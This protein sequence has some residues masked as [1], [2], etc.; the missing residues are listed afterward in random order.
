MAKRF[1]RAFTIVELV[2]VIAVI[3]ILA[4]VLIPTFT[5]LID[6]ANESADLQAVQQMNTIL[7]ANSADEDVENISDVIEILAKEDIDIENY[8]PLSSNRQFYWVKSINRIVYADANYEVVYPENYKDLVREAGQWFSLSGEIKQDDSWKENIEEESGAVVAKISSGEQFASFVK[9][10]SEGDSTA[11]TVEKISLQEDIDLSGATYKFLGDTSN[12]SVGFSQN[13]T[14]DG[15]NHTLYGYRDDSNAFFGSNEFE[16]KGYGYGLFY[17][18]GKDATVTLKNITLSDA[19]AKDTIQD[20][21]TMGLI[22]GYVYGTLNLENVTI[23]N[24]Y[25]E[26]RQKIGGIVG[27][28]YGALSIN[29]L[30]MENVEVVGSVEVAKIA[31][32]V[33]TT[34]KFKAENVDVE[35]VTV[36]VSEEVSPWDYM[37]VFA[38]LQE[39]SA[40]K[41]VID[42]KAETGTLYI[43]DKDKYIW[44]VSTD[45]YYWKVVKANCVIDGENYYLPSTS[46]SEDIL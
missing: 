22:A 15:N 36:K 8:K 1:K 14:I 12:A 11:K 45:D 25:I 43:A 2:I 6:K 10:L 27:Q 13:L 28:L 20:T 39:I 31:S 26:G 44:T 5:T 24:S 46:A 19:V 9:K 17:S 7:A 32:Y 42:G 18:I 3:A 23:K 40:S 41:I 34:G 33:T 29:G 35:G 38:P 37:N 30:K 21:G 4:A 16:N